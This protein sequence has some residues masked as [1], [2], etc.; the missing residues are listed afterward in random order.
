MLHD[1]LALTIL[2]LLVLVSLLLF[3][4]GKL[5]GLI[6]IVF[7]KLEVILFFCPISGIKILLY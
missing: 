3:S 1:I 4:F 6:E 2:L 5:D 7:L